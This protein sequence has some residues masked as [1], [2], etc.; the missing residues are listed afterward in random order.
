MPGSLERCGNTCKVFDLT[1]ACLCIQ[2]FDIAP[3]AFFDRRADINLQEI[4]FSDDGCRHFPQ[5]VVRADKSRYGYNT[6]ID[7][8]F[9]YFGYPADILHPVFRR[10][11]QVV[12]DPATDIISIQDAAQQ[13]AFMQL[14][15]KR[16]SN[17]TLTGTRPSHCA[18]STSA[19]YPPSSSSYR[20]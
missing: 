20:R 9:A 11:A 5:I 6:R 18:A 12:I 17:R 4:L 8:K 3:F 7:K 19:P 10:E 13:T 2:A 1:P 16:N 14:T 15:F